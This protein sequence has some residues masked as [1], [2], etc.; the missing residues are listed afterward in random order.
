VS[1]IDAAPAGAPGPLP[2]LHVVTDDSLLGRGGWEARAVGVLEAGGPDVCLHLRGPRTDGATVHRLAVGLL[3]HAR[4]T[5]ARLVVNDRIDIALAA[6]VHG[7]H[8]GRRSLPV[9]VGRQ[10]LGPGKPLGVSCHDAAEIAAARQGGADYVFGG[11][12]FATPTHPDVPGLGLEGL[13]ATLAGREALPVVAIG[14]IDPAGVAGVLGAG[15]QGIAVVR[16]VWA[17]RDPAGAV[18]RYID[19]IE[20]AAGAAARTR[21]GRQA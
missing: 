17:G 21:E 1:P 16:G 19:E 7:V 10:L 4:R 9:A 18:R 12:I 8:L 3:P 11:T 15:A 5:G 13:A 2:R 6:P 14:G 20:R